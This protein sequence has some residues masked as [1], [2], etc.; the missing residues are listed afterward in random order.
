MHRLA[1]A[2]DAALGENERIERRP[3]RATVRRGDDELVGAHL[4]APRDVRLEIEQMAARDQAHEV[5]AGGDE[6]SLTT[7]PFAPCSQSSTTERAKFL[8]R[9]CGIASS[10]V[11]VNT[12][13]APPQA[14]PQ[15]S[16]MDQVVVESTAREQFNTLLLAIFAAIVVPAW[17]SV[18][19]ATKALSTFAR[20]IRHGGFAPAAASAFAICTPSAPM[21]LGGFG[22]FNELTTRPS[23]LRRDR[24][25][26]KV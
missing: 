4:R 10:S 8:S 18:V 22:P 17:P 26:P 5:S 20:P 21:R 24:Q 16:T 11:G 12:P 25:R 15:P 2:I 23:R 13:P 7:A 1:G 14:A 9:S 3:L 6:N 19:W